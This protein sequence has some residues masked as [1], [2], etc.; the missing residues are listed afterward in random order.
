MSATVLPVV[1]AAP[2]FYFLTLKLRELAIVNYRL[3]DIAATDSLTQCLNRRAFTNKVN[4]WLKSDDDAIAATGALLVVDA[5]HFKL[6]NDRFGHQS[7]DEA[8]QLIAVTIKCAVRINDYVGR[9]GGEEFGIFLPDT[10]PQLAT[11][12]AERI[13]RSIGEAEF[14]PEGLPWQLTVSVGVVL[15]T[16]PM[17]YSELFKTCRRSALHGQGNGP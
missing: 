2:L 1:L 3:E 16:R 13:R 6:V 8:L 11:I 7:G 12:I 14:M 15:F 10:D 9:L 4:H 5:D 17:D